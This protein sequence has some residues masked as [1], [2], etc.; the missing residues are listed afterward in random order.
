MLMDSEVRLDVDEVLAMV[1]WL[2]RHVESFTR[3]ITKVHF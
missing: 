2:G 1:R 3:G